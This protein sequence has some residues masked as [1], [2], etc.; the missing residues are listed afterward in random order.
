[1]KIGQ[2]LLGLIGQRINDGD[3]GVVVARQ[4]VA[5]LGT[6]QVCDFPPLIIMKR[7][8][9]R[10][11]PPKYFDL[12]T[13]NCYRCKN[14]NNCGGCKVLKSYNTKSVRSSAG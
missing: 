11:Q 10:P 14:K 5:L 4:I 13:D 3:F 2:V 12:D 8:K 9:Q 1:M 7:R 6:V